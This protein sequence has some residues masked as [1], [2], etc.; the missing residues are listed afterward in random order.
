MSFNKFLNNKK[1]DSCDYV[2]THSILSMDNRNQDDYFFNKSDLEK[3][4]EASIAEEKSKIRDY[5]RIIKELQN[6]DYVTDEEYDQA[7]DEINMY[8]ELIQL[9]LGE[10]EQGKILID[11][12]KELRRLPTVQEDFDTDF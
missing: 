5:K 1:T 10:I 12:E 7:V 3:Q 6:G 8:E 9:S 4:Y 2:M 11:E